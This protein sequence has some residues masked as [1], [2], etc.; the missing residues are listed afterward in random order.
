MC[1]ITIREFLSEIM[2]QMSSKALQPRVVYVLCNLAVGNLLK[3]EVAEIQSSPPLLTKPFYHVLN[4]QEE[5]LL[6][7]LGISVIIPQEANA[8]MCCGISKVYIYSFGM[9]NV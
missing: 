7:F 2:R 8:V 4:A 3:A 9:T 6:L 5:L 1:S